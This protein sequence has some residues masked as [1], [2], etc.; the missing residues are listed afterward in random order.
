MEGDIDP[1]D[2]QRFV[3]AQATVIGAVRRELNAGRKTSHWMWF[4]FPQLAGLGRS[5][6][7]ERYAIAS[8]EEARA[9]LDHPILGPRLRELTALVNAAPGPTASEIFGA[10]DDAKFRSSMTLF[11]KC[12]SHPAVF[13]QAIDRYF[14][15]VEDSATVSILGR[16][17]GR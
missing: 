1:F 4:M 6:M 5:P 9:Y 12:A 14:A 3:D 15:G 2:L 13:R 11:A 8:G 16:R 7:A 17:E 10:P